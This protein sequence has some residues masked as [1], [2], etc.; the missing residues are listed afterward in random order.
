MGHPGKEGLF[1]DPNL[2]VQFAN[3]LWSTEEA[4]SVP[5]KH[6][7]AKSHSPNFEGGS[8]VHTNTVGI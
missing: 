7:P 6:K 1:S 2:G 4:K 5:H 3:G 8:M